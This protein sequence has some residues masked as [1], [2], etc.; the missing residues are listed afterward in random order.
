[1]AF[2]D[3]IVIFTLNDPQGMTHKIRFNLDGLR[4]IRWEASKRLIYG[5]LVCLSADHFST[6][7]CGTITKYDAKA[8]RRGKTEVIFHDVDVNELSLE[9]TYT[10]IE[11]SAYFEV[12]NNNISVMYQITPM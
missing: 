6:F 10:M 4:G 1:M 8:L 9:K 2:I 12:K 3:I 5:S 11:S 7:I